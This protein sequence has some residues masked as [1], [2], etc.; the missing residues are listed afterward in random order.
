MTTPIEGLYLVGS[1]VGSDNIGTELAAE[2]ALR[3]ASK[4]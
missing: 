3:L 2:S 1:D 4:I